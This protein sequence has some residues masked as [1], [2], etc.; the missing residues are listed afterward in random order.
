M[1]NREIIQTMIQALESEDPTSAGKYLTDDFYWRGNIPKALDKTNFLLLMTALKTG[2]PDYTLG[3]SIC[4]EKGEVIHAT[5]DP[6]GTHQGVFTLPGLVPVKPTGITV[7]L[8]RQSLQLT[9]QGSK[10]AEIKL[11]HA[12]GGG[13]QGLLESIGVDISDEL[14][15]NLLK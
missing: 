7:A 12:S 3:V 6:V 13:I 14:L 5:M 1:T 8:P 10:I 9:L 4:R 2:F 15:D 11:E